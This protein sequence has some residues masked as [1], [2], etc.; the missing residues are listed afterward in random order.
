ML[1]SVAAL[2]LFLTVRPAQA[3]PRHAISPGA[4]GEGGPW[5]LHYHLTL[6]RRFVAGAVA[7]FSMLAGGCQY[8][9]SP[10]G[11]R[12]SGPR[13]PCWLVHPARAPTPA[14][15]DALTRAGVERHDDDDG[16]RR[17]IDRVRVPLSLDRAPVHNALRR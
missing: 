5:G 16:R 4:G 9:F 13:H 12:V 7:S 11:W 6:R 17:G 3:E 1:R 10:Y 8:T 2:L 15:H 14:S